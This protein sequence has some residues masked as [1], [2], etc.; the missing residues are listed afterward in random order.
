MRSNT[1]ASSAHAEDDNSQRRSSLNGPEIPNTSRRTLLGRLSAA[2]AGL[3]AL[4]ALLDAALPYTRA[5]PPAQ[6]ANT[7]LRPPSDAERAALVQ[8]L[9]KVVE[10]PKVGDTAARVG[11][12][13]MADAR[14]YRAKLVV[15]TKWLLRKSVKSICPESWRESGS[16]KPGGLESVNPLCASKARACASEHS[17][18]LQ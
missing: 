10:R 8:A 12:H 5:T 3:L 18:I 1:V 6:A 14:Q 17:T 4:P 16:E 2:P 11:H 9:K 15:N 7:R 13:F